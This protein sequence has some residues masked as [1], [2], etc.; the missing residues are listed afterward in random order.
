M[1]KHGYRDMSSMYACN[2]TSVKVFY[3]IYI[4]IYY[5]YGSSYTFE[6][7]SGLL[8]DPVLQTRA[9]SFQVTHE[10]KCPL[11]KMLLGYFYRYVPKR[12]FN[13]DVLS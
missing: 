8:R 1:K 5:R 13:G 10:K 4:F 11:P 6:H 12:G 7:N 9:T 3:L 2:I